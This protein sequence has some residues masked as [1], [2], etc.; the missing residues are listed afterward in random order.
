MFVIAW[1]CGFG[2]LI[3]FF[4]HF[5]S[6][7]GESVYSARHGTLT[8]SAD[9]QGHYWV[10]GEINQHPVRFVIDTG[11]TYVAVPQALAMKLD[12]KGHYPVMLNTAGGT[13]HG[14]LTRARH[15]SFSGFTFNNVKV[16]IM[17]DV[18]TDTALLGMNVLSQFSITQKNNQLIIKR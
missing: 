9:A 11:A 4:H 12:L 7:K 18:K 1:I 5:G 3:L 8:I 10:D 17:P 2:L 15:M 14:E 13:V 16:V 6:E